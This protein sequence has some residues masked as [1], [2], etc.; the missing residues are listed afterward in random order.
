MEVKELLKRKERA[1]LFDTAK[2]LIPKEQVNIQALMDRR[3]NAKADMD[4]WRSLL[5]TAYKYAVPN[6]NPWVNLGMAGAITP[7]EILNG[8]IYDLTLP[9][10]HQKLTN[11]LLM[12]MVPQGQ[13]WVK[14][15]PGNEFGQE[16]EAQYRRALTQTQKFTDHFFEILDRSNFYLTVS[17]SMSD[18]LISTGVLAINEG[19]RKKPFRFESIPASHI[20][21]EGNA[22]GSIC[23]VFRDWYKV[24]V[25]YINQLWPEAKL[26]NN[27]EGKDVVDI[28]ECATIDY[29]A[30]EKERCRY[31]V[32]TSVQEI[33]YELASP[34]WPW[35]IYRMRKL[36]GETRGRGPSLDA[37]PTAATINMAVGDELVAAAFTA[38]PM[39]MAAGG[40]SAFNPDTFRARPGCFVPVQMVMGQWPLQQ[41][42]GGGDINFSALV[43]NDFR[44]QINELLFTAPLGPINAP[45]KTATEQQIRYTE[46]LE[47]FMA[48]A[49]RLQTE[50]F[51]PTIKRCMYI[52]NRVIPEIFSG[53]DA[54]IREKLISVDGQL[55][56]LRYETPLMTARGQIKATALMSY[57]QT[58]A[59]MVGPE[60]AAATLKPAKLTQAVAQYM[61]ANLE[62]IKDE[63]EID[64]ELAVAGQVAQEQIDEGMIPGASQ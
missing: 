43:I 54:D 46:N 61:G 36:A 26:P 62:V 1:N 25:D 24:R 29:R 47:N 41:F 27:K 57:F 33:L 14:F 23:G 45:D 32:M 49:P 16:G 22:D 15:V 30:D 17:E 59:S 40:D 38:N 34:S 2:A 18:A 8:D 7:G 3:N 19:D 4:M 20:M 31:V 5:E 52:L 50:F 56:G 13:Q 28:Y 51:D 21:F 42:P 58:L 53:M 12:G 55:L 10:A 64:Q 35:V 11:K 60:A 37:Y 48:V 63:Q 6:Y 44:Q 39:Y 9:I